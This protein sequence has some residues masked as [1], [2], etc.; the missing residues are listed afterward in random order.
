MLSI[1]LNSFIHRV[2]DKLHVQNLV[3]DHGCQLKRIRRSR[4]WILT[5]EADQLRRLLKQLDQGHHQWIIKAISH[6]L[7]TPTVS[8]QQLLT[9]Q[10]NLTVNQLVILTEC[11]MEEAR[12]AIDTHEGF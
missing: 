10:P 9:E 8:L 5:G 6:A 11:T 3:A 2:D 12:R 7:P 4:H 1:P